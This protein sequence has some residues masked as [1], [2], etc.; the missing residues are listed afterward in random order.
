MSA[1]L[2]GGGLVQ[3]RNKDEGAAGNPAITGQGRGLLSARVSP[4]KEHWLW[5]PWACPSQ[6]TVPPLATCHLLV[7]EMPGLG[8]QQLRVQ[9][10]TRPKA[11]YKN[12]SQETTSKWFPKLQERE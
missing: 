6:V 7:C 11:K 4:G 12:R 1:G 9:L 5:T 8:E 3:K 2:E 10:K